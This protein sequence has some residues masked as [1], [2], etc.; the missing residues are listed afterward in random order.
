MTPASI[1]H[2]DYR[3]IPKIREQIRALLV[4]RSE[5]LW[6][7]A[8]L[9]HHRAIGVQRFFVFD[10]PG[11]AVP[12]APGVGRAKDLSRRGRRIFNRSINAQTISARRCI[13]K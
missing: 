12:R 10:D 11:L 4:V 6:L 7:P 3:P 2:L 13:A 8:T 1:K 5:E 9:R